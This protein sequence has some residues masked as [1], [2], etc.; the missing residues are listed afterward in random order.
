MIR[1]KFTVAYRLRLLHKQP[2]KQ[3]IVFIWYSIVTPNF[4]CDKLNNLADQ[5]RFEQS[6]YPANNKKKIKS[7][8][9]QINK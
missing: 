7:N 6:K 5:K 8:Q 4:S 2:N 9:N 1:L 3:T